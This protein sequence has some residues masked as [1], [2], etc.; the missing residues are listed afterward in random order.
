M[1]RQVED[2]RTIECSLPQEMVNGTEDEQYLSIEIRPSTGDQDNDSQCWDWFKYYWFFKSIHG[3][4]PYGSK[5]VHGSDG[6]ARVL[7]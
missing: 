7:D 2:S 5:Y 3:V 6:T 4:M 1:K